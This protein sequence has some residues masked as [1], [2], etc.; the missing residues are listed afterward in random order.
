[1]V[2]IGSEQ[3]YNMYVRYG[4]RKRSNHD[5]DFLSGDESTELMNASDI[6]LMLSGKKLGSVVDSLFPERKDA[7]HDVLAWLDPQVSMNHMSPA[8][9]A[10]ILDDIADTVSK[11]VT[12]DPTKDAA[13][14]KNNKLMSD[15]IDDINKLSRQIR[16]RAKVVNPDA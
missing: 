15:F 12:D 1:M 7:D 16:V 13:I 2:R 9:F 6:V 11:L 10:G 4:N 14:L 3:Q 5:S 8:R